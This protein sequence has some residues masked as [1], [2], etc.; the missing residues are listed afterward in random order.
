MEQE[1][2][3]DEYHFLAWIERGDNENER[4]KERVREKELEK[5]KK[6]RVRDRKTVR[7]VGIQ[8][9]R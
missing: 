1:V 9:P 8:G 4:E 7:E 6:E 3:Y 5:E 2:D